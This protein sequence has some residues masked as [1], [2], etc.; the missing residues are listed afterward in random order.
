M[1]AGPPGEGDAPE[2]G[3]S[4]AAGQ[5]QGFGRGDRLRRR[6]EF[7]RAY[8]SGGRRGGRYAT[9]FVVANGLGHPRLGVTA[10]RKTG[11]SVVRQRLKRRV[12]EIYRRWHRRTELP[13]VDLVVNLKPTAAA[14]GFAE[15]RQELER[16]MVSL[17]A[18]AE[19]RPRRGGPAS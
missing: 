8:R 3:G 7:L 5:R 1:T 19:R 12:R 16:Q 10:S 18:G 11:K 4:G 14:A 6:N 17:L 2:V 13:P 15:L 9:L